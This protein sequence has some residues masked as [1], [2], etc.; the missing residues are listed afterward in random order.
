MMRRRTSTIRYI[1]LFVVL[2]GT[3][4]M[5]TLYGEGFRGIPD[6]IGSVG[7]TKFE[8]G[9]NLLEP[10]END[11][12]IMKTALI[13]TT[14]GSG[15][16][17]TFDTD[18]NFS[19]TENN[20]QI[21]NLAATITTKPAAISTNSNRGDTKGL[22]NSIPILKATVSTTEPPAAPVHIFS[23]ALL[24]GTQGLE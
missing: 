21:G 24:Q 5:S 23:N 4:L 9:S 16:M 3:I 10:Y 8:G 7:I 12:Y 22:M 6:D 15:K 19:Q 11:T 13:D 2:C 1:I 14:N 18:G 20:I 17:Y